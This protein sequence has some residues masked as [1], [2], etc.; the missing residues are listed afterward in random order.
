M[1]NFFQITIAT[2]GGLIGWLV[3]GWSVLLTVL[4]ILNTFDFI[5]GMAANWGQISSKRGYEGII[6]KG[7]MWVWIVVAN[8][9]YLVLDHQGLKI[10][11]VIP[12]AVAILFILNEVASLGENSAKLGINIPEPVQRALAIFDKSE[13]GK[14]NK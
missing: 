1:E 12:N 11:G 10:G 14:G 4:L 8:L 5:T 6:K 3:G 7:M 9:I 2:I 13:K